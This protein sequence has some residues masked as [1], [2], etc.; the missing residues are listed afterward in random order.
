MDDSILYTISKED[1]LDVC[2]CENI[3][4]TDHQLARVYTMIENLDF[5][6]IYE[7]IERAIAFV[8][9]DDRI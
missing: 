3:T 1:V 8:L 7:E 2:E 4:L 5:S 9:E 6:P